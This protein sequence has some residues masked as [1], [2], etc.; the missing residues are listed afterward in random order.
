MV[1]QAIRQAGYKIRPVAKAKSRRVFQWTVI[2]PNENSFEAAIH[3]FSTQGL[4]YTADATMRDTWFARFVSPSGQRSFTYLT[5]SRLIQ[6]A[7]ALATLTLIPQKLFID[8]FSR[9][10][11]AWS[12]VHHLPG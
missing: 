8:S 1:P 10:L 11:Q 5:L 6:L 4:A 3:I 7:F 9:L 12:W 2:C